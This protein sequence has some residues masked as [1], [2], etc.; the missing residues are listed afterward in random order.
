[1]WKAGW[2]PA[3]VAARHS[4]VSW[5]QNR[6]VNAWLSRLSS[7]ADAIAVDIS[8]GLAR[9][10]DRIDGR[11]GLPRLLAPENEIGGFGTNPRALVSSLLLQAA[12]VAVAMLAGTTQLA[13]TAKAPT[14]LIAPPQVKSTRTNAKQA[15]GGG[16]H[17]SLP[18]LKGQ[19][20]KPAPK[21]FRSLL[22]TT[23]H[24]ALVMDAS[25]IAPPDAW[26]TPTGPIGNPLG[27]FGGAHGPGN[28]GG[29]G[30]G[31]GP[32]IGDKAG[33]GAG[34]AGDAGIFNVGNGTS[35]PEVIDKVD[36]EYSEEARK[37]KYSGAV[38]L[39]IVV[40]ADGW[41][42]DIKVVRSLGMGL[43]EK[44]VEAVRRWRFR[45]GMYKG[46]A[47]RVRALIE[48]NFRLL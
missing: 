22:V 29:M 35:K 24:P 34:D 46:V 2:P 10:A 7:P 36:P 32:G 15:G 26:T 42:A 1:M 39:S 17:S 28:N 23:E 5:Q 33:A 8:A 12:I 30:I 20:P 14:E 11:G 44:A 41:A 9:I 25:L 37:A 18:P 38:I 6:R 4:T 48:V 47:V 45:P 43:D 16:Q 21:V 3:P 27:L 31:D 40:N 19:L 13:P